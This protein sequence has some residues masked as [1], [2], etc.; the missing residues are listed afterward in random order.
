MT[1]R[2][3]RQHALGFGSTPAQVTCQI[4]GNTIYSG[5][6][7]ALNQP[8]PALPDPTYKIDNIA[9]TW[10]GDAD[11]TGTQN[12][13][14]T[15]SGADLL[16]GDTLA[17]N[18]YGIDTNDFGSFYFTTVDGVIYADPFTNEKIDNVS[19]S[20][21]Y[22]PNLRGQWWWWIPAGSTFSATL[23]IE[24]AVAPPPEPNSP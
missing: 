20:G 14:I 10:Q 22:D 6:V 19:Q 24:A 8:K 2:I 7:T 4:E 21:P 18:P 3:F 17:N 5:A 15:V 11:F 16:L 9:W 12:M 23:N 1:D 13:I